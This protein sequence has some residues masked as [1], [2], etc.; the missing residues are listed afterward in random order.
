MA[1]NEST[2][3]IAGY[4][5]NPPA[6]KRSSPAAH[7]ESWFDRGLVA[8]V[9]AEDASARIAALEELALEYWNVAVSYVGHGL[10]F[11]FVLI[12]ILFAVLLMLLLAWYFRPSPPPVVPPAVDV[13]PPQVAE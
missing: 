1:A 4:L 11:Q 6:S 2:G 9:R 8:M 13:V 7:R 10:I 3:A 5:A 12:V